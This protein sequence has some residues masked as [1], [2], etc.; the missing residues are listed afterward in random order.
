MLKQRISLFIAFLLI[1]PNVFASTYDKPEVLSF[2]ASKV[3]LDTFDSNLKVAFELVVS[4]PAGIAES[5]TSLIVGSDGKYTLATSLNRTDNPINPKLQKVTFKGEIEFPR[6]FPAGLY[7]YSAGSVTSNLFD[8]RKIPTGEITGPKLRSLKGADTGIILR[9]NGYLDLAEDI[10]NG[11]SYKT[12]NSEVYENP[13]KFLAAPSPIFRVGEKIDLRTYF[14]VTVDEVTL[15]AS[16]LTPKIC[17]VTNEIVT[18]LAIGS[19]TYT[20]STSRSKNYKSQSI[21]DTISIDTER[22]PQELFV[23][24]VPNQLASNIP[25]TI[26]LDAVYSSGISAV[27]YVFPETITKDICDVSGYSLR[28]TSGGLCKLTYKSAGNDKYLPSKIYIQEILIER[29]EQ[30]INFSLPE[31]INLNE[32]TYTLTANALSGAPILFESS[33]KE[34]CTVTSNLVQFLGLGKCI[35][36]ALQPGTAQFNP[37]SDSRTVLV[38]SEPIVK[39]CQNIKDKKTGKKKKVCK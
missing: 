4:H 15:S 27:Q 20:A 9:S 24:K 28:I 13:A 16:S 29:K 10:L 25:I 1:S 34:V 21:S 5:S 18:F 31:K 37:V 11:P 2:T 30:S 36:T 6:N 17:S 33:T 35:I 32:K 19:C 26:M 22:L 12:T 23:P 14:E 8:G 7:P 39:K 38:F 3:D